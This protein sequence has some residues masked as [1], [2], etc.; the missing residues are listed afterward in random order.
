MNNLHKNFAG[1]H[2]DPVQF[3]ESQMESTGISA[4]NRRQ[5]ARTA[6][7]RKPCFTRGG[8]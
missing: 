7:L 4:K 5:Q 6:I 8:K 1:F 2:A 3:A